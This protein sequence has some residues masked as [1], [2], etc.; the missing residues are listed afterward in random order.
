MTLTVEGRQL[1][2][3]VVQGASASD[4]KYLIILKTITQLHIEHSVCPQRSNCGN[5]PSAIATIDLHKIIHV[6]FDNI[7]HLV[8]T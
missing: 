5:N 1:A 6:N 4:I 3:V 7:S 2:P 8:D